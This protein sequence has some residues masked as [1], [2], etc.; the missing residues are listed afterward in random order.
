VEELAEVLGV[1]FGATG[2]APK[3]GEGLRWEI[4][5]QAVLS[6]C[7]GL[8]AVVEDGSSRVIQFSHFSVKEFLTSDRLSALID[9][10]TLIISVG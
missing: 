1:D 6:A 9:A 5:A 4:Q 8:I 10:S 3:L 2:R 7:S